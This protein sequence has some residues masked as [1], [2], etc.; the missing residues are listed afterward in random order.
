MQT[1][2]RGILANCSDDNTDNTQGSAHSPLEAP[3]PGILVVTP[4]NLTQ[5][6]QSS[7]SFLTARRLAKMSYDSDR[8]GL[9]VLRFGANRNAACR[10][11]RKRRL[12]FDHDGVLFLE[13]VKVDLNMQYVRRSE[14]REYVARLCNLLV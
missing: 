2:S 4:V 13:G 8:R 6:T 5:Y 9:V 1:F 12:F 3:P 14:E 10:A 7:R 11:C